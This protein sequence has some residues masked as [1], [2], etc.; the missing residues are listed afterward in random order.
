MQVSGSQASRALDAMRRTRR[1]GAVRRRRWRRPVAAAAPAPVELVLRNLA[2]LPTT[3]V[4]VIQAASGR[5]AAG[6][7]PSAD[8]VAE[9]ALRRA[10]CD[11]LR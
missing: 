9:M 6:Q 7:L 5:L 1:R 2:D 10:I 4:E 11:R 3:R 8:A